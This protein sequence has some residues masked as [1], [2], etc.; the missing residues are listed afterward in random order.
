MEESYRKDVASHPGSESCRRRCRKAGREAL[1]GAQAGQDTEQTTTL[2]T[3]GRAGVS[4][5]LG[6]CAGSDPRP[7]VRGQ[8]RSRPVFWGPRLVLVAVLTGWPIGFTAKICVWTK[9]E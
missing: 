4:I 6:R 1:T 9:A 5:G 3:Q 8:E 2:R 7:Y